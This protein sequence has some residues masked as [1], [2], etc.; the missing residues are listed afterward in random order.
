MATPEDWLSKIPQ[1][2]NAPPL[3]KE[4]MQHFFKQIGFAKVLQEI[5]QRVFDEA[6]N[7]NNGKDNVRV[8]SFPLITGEP[9]WKYDFEVIVKAV[10]KTQEQ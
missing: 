4:D 8:R 1:D 6:T 9:Q 7:I 2:P 10:R 5:G 3:T